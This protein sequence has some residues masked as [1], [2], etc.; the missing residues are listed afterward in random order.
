MEEH[1]LKEDNFVKFFQ[2]AEIA[3]LK[4]TE[5][6]EYEASLNTYRD[7]KNSLDWAE[8]KGERKKAIDV[9]LRMH[10]KAYPIEEIAEVTNMSIAE[11]K[12]II[13]KYVKPSIG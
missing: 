6:Q 8:L 11:V 12:A 2:I 3:K 1:I 10:G 5:Y 9:V 4:E 13:D 7:I